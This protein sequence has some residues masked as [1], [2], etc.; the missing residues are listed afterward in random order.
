MVTYISEGDSRSHEKGNSNKKEG[1]ITHMMSTIITSKKRNEWR[2]GTI[3]REGSTHT[4]TVLHIGECT[5]IGCSSSQGGTGT[6]TKTAR[7]ITEI[8]KATIPDL[9]TTSHWA[10]VTT[11]LRI[12][13]NGLLNAGTLNTRFHRALH[14]SLVCFTSSFPF[15]FA[16]EAVW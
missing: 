7:T 3:R 10:L 14:P 16:F 9:T 8:T 15:S 2:K 12:F 13:V 1:K 4:I 11:G 5:T 6:A